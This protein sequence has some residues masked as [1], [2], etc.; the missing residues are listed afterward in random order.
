MS[1]PCSNQNQKDKDEQN[2]IASL[3]TLLSRLLYEFG[4]SPKAYL[5]LLNG[6]SISEIR[7]LQKA[8]SMQTLKPRS[9]IPAGR[10]GQG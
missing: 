9:G 10:I 2:R 4:H 3:K 5:R 1:C 8:T 7:A 6:L